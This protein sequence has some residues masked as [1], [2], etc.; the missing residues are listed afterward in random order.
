MF[1]LCVCV[2]VCVCFTLQELIVGGLKPDT[3][4]FVS[5]AAYTTKGDGTHSK[6]KVVQ[7]LGLG[8]TLSFCLST[9]NRLNQRPYLTAATDDMGST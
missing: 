7:T 9:D 5:V 2:C 3:S 6:A 8:K 1:S 4:Y